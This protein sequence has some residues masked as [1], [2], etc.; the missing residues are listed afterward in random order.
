[1]KRAGLFLLILLITLLSF[2]GCRKEPQKNADVTQSVRQ[3]EK[4]SARVRMTVGEK[5]SEYLVEKRAD[6][7]T[8][9]CTAPEM[10][11]DLRIVLKEDEYSVSYLGIDFVTKQLPDEVRLATAPI[12][13]FLD[14][15]QMEP[16]TQK[17]GENGVT[18][19]TYNDGETAFECT[20]DSET[21]LPVSL[22]CGSDIFLEFLEFTISPGEASGVYGESGAADAA[23]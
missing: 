2:A 19:V 15:L 18:A 4:F 11:K 8:V 16:G 3:A 9:V 22:K 12:F 13:R 23:G 21:K 1:M 6:A 7:I 14:V 5:Q 10:I 20:F 17:P